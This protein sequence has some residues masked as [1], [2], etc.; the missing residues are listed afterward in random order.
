MLAALQLLAE[1]NPS[2]QREVLAHAPR[3]FRK[4]WR[5]LVTESGAPNRRLYRWPY[6]QPCATSL[7]SS[8]IWVER[9]PSYR[10]FDSYLL[11]SSA[12]LV[13][14]GSLACRQQQ[15]SG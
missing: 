14:A 3:P 11:P 2:G 6:S 15:M 4:E 12:I 10:R 5:R 1:L 8:D 9:S 13:A 7:R